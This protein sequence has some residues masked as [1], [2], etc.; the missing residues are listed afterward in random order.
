MNKN[1][2]QAKQPL[3][4]T[5]KPAE[6]LATKPAQPAQPYKGPTKGTSFKG[7]RHDTNR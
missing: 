4:T 2:Q 6:H 1:Q 5:K 7:D 3:N